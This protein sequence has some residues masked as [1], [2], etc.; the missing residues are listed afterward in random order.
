[1]AAAALGSAAILHR[2]GAIAKAA[3]QIDHGYKFLKSAGNH[4]GKLA[5]N[6]NMTID[7]VRAANKKNH[8]GMAEKP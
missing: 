1:M 4:I 7:D 5:T 6:P 3:K 2:S 8:A